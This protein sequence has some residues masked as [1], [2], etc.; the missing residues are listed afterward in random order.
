MLDVLS[1]NWLPFSLSL[2]ETPRRPVLCLKI[3]ANCRLLRSSPL[4]SLHL[5]R[6]RDAHY[7]M[8]VAIQVE[9]QILYL[10]ALILDSNCKRLVP[11]AAID[12]QRQ[13]TFK[14]RTTVSRVMV[15]IV[16]LIPQH[17]DSIEIRFA[18]FVRFF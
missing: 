8:L 6:R 14:I 16:L 13:I 15:L 9:R 3:A 18:D 12:A 10:A 1:A 4:C 7:I 11:T 5:L 2:F 17:V